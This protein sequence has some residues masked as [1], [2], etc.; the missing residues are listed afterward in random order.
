MYFGNTY[1]HLGG[2][3][4]VLTYNSMECAAM[5]IK[6]VALSTTNKYGK[7]VH[8]KKLQIWGKQQ[9]KMHFYVKLSCLRLI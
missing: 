1:V 3:D 9:G 4:V 5:H 6:I 2:K 7:K 8:W